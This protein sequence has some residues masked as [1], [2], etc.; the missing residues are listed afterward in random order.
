[1]LGEGWASPVQSR[2]DKKLVFGQRSTER[3]DLTPEQREAAKYFHEPGEGDLMGHYD[4]RYF[5]GVVSDEERTDTQLHMIRAYLNFFNE[6]GLDTWI[7]HG[8]L[9]GWWWNGKRLPW[10]WDMDTQV[11]GATLQ[12]LGDHYNQ[13]RHVYTF[14]DGST[15]R[16]YLLDVNPWI[17]ERERG[18]GMNIIDARWVDVSNGLF[19]DI[20]GLSETHPDTAPGTWVCKN[21]HRYKT[22]DLYPMRETVFEGVPAKVP[23]S[24]DKILIEEYKEKALVVTEFQGHQWDVQQKLW[25]KTPEQ[26]ERDRKEEEQHRKNR[27]EAMR[28]GTDKGEK[29][30]QRAA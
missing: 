1:M 23:Y 21:Y 10:D 17:W 14:P 8:T 11:S 2:Q 22:S 24:Y 12:Y 20:T 30:L 15:Q 13:T 27:E 26:A 29:A 7:A 25:I 9:L 28:K 19:I 5:H 3:R 6:R 16:E 4:A 18:D